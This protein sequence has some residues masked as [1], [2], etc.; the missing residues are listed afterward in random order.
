MHTWTRRAPWAPW[1]LWAFWVLQALWVFWASGALVGS[2]PETHKTHKTQKAQKAC[3]AQKTQA[4]PEGAARP[5][6]PWTGLY[7][8]FGLFG[9]YGFYWLFGFYRP[10]RGFRGGASKDFISILIVIPKYLFHCLARWQ[11]KKNGVVVPILAFSGPPL[12]CISAF[13]IRGTANAACLITASWQIK[14]H[15]PNIGKCI[16]KVHC[17]TTT[18]RPVEMHRLFKKQCIIKSPKR[19]TTICLISTNCIRCV[20]VYVCRVHGMCPYPWIL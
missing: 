14:T 8:L 12:Q 13:N 6:R 1:V 5:H 18:N 3:R 17:F 4:T 10:W 15:R 11:K 9:F 2:S 19:I 7:R 16:N 20:C